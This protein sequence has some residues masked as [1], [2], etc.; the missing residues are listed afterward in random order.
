[1]TYQLVIFPIAA[2]YILGSLDAIWITRRRLLLEW[3]YIV[4]GLLNSLW[5]WRLLLLMDLCGDNIN[6]V[7]YGGFSNNFEFHFV[8]VRCRCSRNYLYLLNLLLVGSL[9]ESARCSTFGAL[10]WSLIFT[11][12]LFVLKWDT[13][14]LFGLLHQIHLIEFLLIWYRVAIRLVQVLIKWGRCLKLSNLDW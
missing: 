9:S 10:C 11:G 14:S 4:L 2:M 3:N 7:I 13:C 8:S 5:W 12:S 6:M 1:M